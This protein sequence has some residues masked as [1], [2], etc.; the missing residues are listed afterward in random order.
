MT[1][2]ERF[3]TLY[4]EM[5]GI[6]EQDIRDLYAD[7]VVFIDP[8]TRHYGIQGVIHYFMNLLGNVESCTFTLHDTLTV[9]PNP[10]EFSWTVNWTMTLTLKGKSTTTTLDGVTLLKSDGEKIT[11]H[12][13]FYDIGQ[14]VYEHIPVLS[15]VIKKIKRR[16]AQ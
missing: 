16:L 11:Y 10:N 7:D 6:T 4:Q 12:R 2:L 8:V 14:M 3:A 9:A 13:D 15:W 1:V 5:A